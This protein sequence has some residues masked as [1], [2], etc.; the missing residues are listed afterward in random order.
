MGSEKNI[1]T[2]CPFSSI[3]KIFKFIINC[4]LDILLSSRSPSSEFHKLISTI[5]QFVCKELFG[6]DILLEHQ[7]QQQ[8]T[9]KNCTIWWISWFYES[10]WNNDLLSNGNLHHCKFILETLYIFHVTLISFLFK[11]CLTL[12]TLLSIFLEDIF[13]NLIKK[14]K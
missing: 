3:L 1:E 13:L 12:R 10:S 14:Q 6:Q 8:K 5:D 7:Q 4:Q 2:Q 9:D 11:K